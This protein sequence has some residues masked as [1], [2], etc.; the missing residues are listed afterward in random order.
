[1]SITIQ[2]PLDPELAEVY[3]RASTENQRKLQILV[4][5]WLRDMD[6]ANPATLSKLMDDIS[7]KAVQR[8]LTPEILESLLND[9]E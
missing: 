1:M 9:E 6:S 3:D 2:I 4:R 8:G 7:D 5:L